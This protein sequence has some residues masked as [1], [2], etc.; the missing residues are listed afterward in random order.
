[1]L[2]LWRNGAAVHR[3]DVAA[4]ALFELLHQLRQQHL[5][6]QIRT[7]KKHLRTS[8]TSFKEP[9]R[10]EQAIREHKESLRCVEA[11]DCDRAAEMVGKHLRDATAAY[12]ELWKKRKVKV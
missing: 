8:F 5:Q 7:T 10:M 4:A 9:A 2:V 1:M 6:E 12:I 11:K 3:H